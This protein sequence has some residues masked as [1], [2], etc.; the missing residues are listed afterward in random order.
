M[1][2]EKQKYLYYKTNCEK[3]AEELNG[4]LNTQ[5]PKIEYLKVLINFD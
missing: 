1:L 3:A 2:S 4:K 5:M